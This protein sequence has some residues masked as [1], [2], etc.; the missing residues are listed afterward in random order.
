M[1][2]MRD[3][4]A[5]CVAALLVAVAGLAACGGGDECDA[6]VPAFTDLQAAQQ[7]RCAGAAV[8]SAA[9][10]PVAAAVASPAVE[11]RVEGSIA[12]ADLT[13]YNASGGTEQISVDLPWVLRFT[14]RP[15]QF[16]YLSATN[17]TATGALSA[18]LSIDGAVLQQATA[19]R[20]YGNATV[21]S[22]CCGS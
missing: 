4:A 21:R 10:A 20:P 2:S 5:A 13:I 18:R 8:A 1:K 11:Y 22:T 12:R 9:A 3:R 14:G 19:D 15:G 6:G 7:R 16:L 17:P